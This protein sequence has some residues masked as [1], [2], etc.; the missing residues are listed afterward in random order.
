MEESESSSLKY[1]NDN[2]DKVKI[3]GRCTK[4]KEIVT[5]NKKAME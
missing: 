4:K 5:A 2:F 3:E 1:N